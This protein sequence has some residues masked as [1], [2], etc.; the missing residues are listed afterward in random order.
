[1][2]AL[3]TDLAAFVGCVNFVLLD[4]NA[5]VCGNC[6]LG[7]EAVFL[8]AV[9]LVLAPALV[10]DMIITSGESGRSVLI[11]ASFVVV[12]GVVTALG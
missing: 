9:M 8:L 11:C 5:V 7:D 10:T 2:C 6:F 12:V 3:W 4:A 1:M